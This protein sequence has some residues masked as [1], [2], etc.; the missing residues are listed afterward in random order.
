[1]ISDRAITF[2]SQPTSLPRGFGCDLSDETERITVCLARR[3]EGWST[4]SIF[5]HAD[6]AINNWKA[7][8]IHNAIAR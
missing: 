6:N 1:M 3:Y 4:A 5:L 7:L 8:S 2:S